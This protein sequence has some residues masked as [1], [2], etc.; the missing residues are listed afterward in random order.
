[1]KNIVG[2]YLGTT[3]SAIAKIN[4]LGRPEISPDL[5]GNRITAST[6]FFDES[7]KTIVGDAAKSSAGLSPE[8][9]A[10]IFKR[11]MGEPYY[12]GADGEPRIIAD[13]K[14]SPVELSAILLSKIKTDFEKM[15]G[16][17]DYAV[18]TVPA[19]FDEK[20]RKATMDA[21]KLAKL[22]ITNIINEPTAAGLYYATQQ[23]IIGE[24]VVFDLGGGTFDVTLMT[25]EK[26][27]QN[28]VK[29]E[30][31]TSFGDH[32]L[33]G[34][35]FDK[36]IVNEIIA[37]YK[38]KY[39][40][41]VQL[42]SGEYY[43]LMETAESIKKDLSK[44]EELTK[45]I[46]LDKGSLSYT[47]SRSHFE[48]LIGAYFE[49]IEMLCESVLDE[50]N[51]NVSQIKQVILVGGSSRIPLV[52]RTIKKVYGMEPT[53]VGNMD[54]SVAL[55]AALSAGI[56]VANIEGTSVLDKEAFDNLN[57]VDIEDVSN[58]GYGTLILDYDKELGKHI[59]VNDILIPKN[60]KLPHSVKKTFYTVN[61]NQTTVNISVTQGNS[62]SAD[63]VK[64]LKKLEMQLPSGRPQ[65]QPLEFKYAYDV[66][67][68]MTCEFFDVNSGRREEIKLS[69]TGDV[70]ENEETDSYDDIEDFLDF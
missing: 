21:A 2:I 45:V 17:I 63:R 58:S 32:Q 26:D 37:S 15:H 1:M 65:G 16:N 11:D 31:K 19:Y 5:E 35:D 56:S 48:T 50:A 10:E 33:G 6:I 12:R 30:I 61:D 24:T 51:I 28:G 70:S 57:S 46:R 18:I 8:R 69:I 20:R 29:V 66:N 38:E 25:I 13:K 4:T 59:L 22:N 40:Y 55:G 39:S 34:K 44:K 52:T 9:Y 67:Q 60:T 7:G 3:F 54:E 42:N 62:E 41:E 49:K 27:N 23:N 43:E 14:W 36:E 64:I 47:I 53:L 68:R